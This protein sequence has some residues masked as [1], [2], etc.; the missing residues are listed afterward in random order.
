MSYAPGPFQ[1]LRSLKSA[2][3]RP[4]GVWPV[5]P[6]RTDSGRFHCVLF[7]NLFPNELALAVPTL[8]G[9]LSEAPETSSG[10]MLRSIP[11]IR[12][13]RP[14]RRLTDGAC[15]SR[16]N[17]GTRAAPPASAV[18]IGRCDRLAHRHAANVAYRRSH[19]G[20]RLDASGGDSASERGVVFFVLLGVCVCKVGYGVVELGRVA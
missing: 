12:C 7:P 8:V 3:Q 6:H 14:I 4:S 13:R 1:C 2:G 5:A 16:Y 17:S 15:T 20:L 18:L 9:S 19:R 10:P 11:P